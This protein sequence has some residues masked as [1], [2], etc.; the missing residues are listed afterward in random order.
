[1]I[2][3]ESA[4]N[5]IKTD[6]ALLDYLYNAVSTELSQSEIHSQKVSFVM[7]FV[8]EESGVTRDQVENVLR[9]NEGMV[10]A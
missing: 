9:R 2:L 8:K 10:V 3:E 1:V 4:V 5:D 7:G 6:P